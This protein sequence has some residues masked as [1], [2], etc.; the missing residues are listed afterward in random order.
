MFSIG[1]ETGF[2]RHFLMPALVNGQL[3]TLQ[4]INYELVLNASDIEFVKLLD[5]VNGTINITDSLNASMREIRVT[6]IPGEVIIEHCANCGYLFSDCLEQTE[7]D[8]CSD[9]LII[10][11]DFDVMCQELHGLC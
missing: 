11:A 8:G 4:L 9:I 6:K 2:S 5:G 10:D 7:W 3:Y 1:K